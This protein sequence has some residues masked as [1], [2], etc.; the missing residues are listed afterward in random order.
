MT[1]ALI[2]SA[3]LGLASLMVGCGASPDGTS[4]PAPAGSGEH[5]LETASLRSCDCAP[6]WGLPPGGYPGCPVK[7][8]AS[9]SACNAYCGQQ[10]P[11]PSP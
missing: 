6:Q 11:P 10:C 3:L 7:S 5:D 9:V 8:V 2:V 4:G 1:R